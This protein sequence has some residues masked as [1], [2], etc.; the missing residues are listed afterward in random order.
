VVLY[1]LGTWSLT[2]RNE[3]RPRVFEDKVLRRLSGEKKKELTGGW[4]KLPNE[5]LLNLV[6]FARFN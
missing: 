3:N 2:L 1:G 5:D 4:R 6:L